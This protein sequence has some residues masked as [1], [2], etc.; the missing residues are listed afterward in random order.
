MF[1]NI[2]RSEFENINF[3]SDATSDIDTLTMGL[4]LYEGIETFKLFDKSI[5]ESNAFRELQSK[6]ILQVKN[7]ILKIDENYMIKLD[8]VI[9]FLTNP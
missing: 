9:D 2:N 4:R 6:K 3:F 7:D 8:S 5:I 1:K